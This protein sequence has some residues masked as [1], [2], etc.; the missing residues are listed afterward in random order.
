MHEVYNFLE[1]SQQLWRLAQ[2]GTYHDTIE[3]A[4]LKR[5][6]DYRFRSLA[7]IDQTAFGLISQRAELLYLCVNVVANEFGAE[8]RERTAIREGRVD[9]NCED[10]FRCHALRVSC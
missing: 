4:R 2:S 9:A 1:Q 3:G 5:P 10:G 6:F 7:Q 8:F